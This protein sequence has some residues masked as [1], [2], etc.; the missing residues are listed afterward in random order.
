[1]T[2]VLTVNA[3]SSTIRLN[4]FDCSE[5]PP[6]N[7][8]SHVIHLASEKRTPQQLLQLC[9]R[10]ARKRTPDLIAHRVVHGGPWLS[11]NCRIDAPVEAKI[12]EVAHLA[13]L[14][15]PAALEW[16][17]ACRAQFGADTPQVACFDT[18]EF[19]ELPA[20]AREYPLPAALRQRW[21]L[22]RYGFHGLAHRSM[23]AQFA[24]E[25]AGADKNGRVITL[26]LGSGCS[27]AAFLAGRPIDTSM[28][29][30]PLEGLMMGTRAGDLDPGLLLFLLDRGSLDYSKLASV[31]HERSGLLGVSERSADIR[32]LLEA[33]DEAS[34]LA[35]E[36]FCY[37][38][39]K[40]VGS[41]AAALQGLDAVVFGGGIGENSPDVRRRIME[42]LEFFGIALDA[43]L[44]EARVSHRRRITRPHSKVEVWVVAVDEAALLVR[45]ALDVVAKG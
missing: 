34:R 33:N 36:M 1:M 19:A 5:T 12:A 3:G 18:V 45:E 26:Q 28:G 35:V 15:N 42:P 41:Y 10:D 14:H 39:S 25:N 30:S 7:H 32:D 22:R 44:N 37:R 27:A 4:L 6:L 40:Y 11:A 23:M 9:L 2:E 24:E 16:I 8:V 21:H 38:V 20:I 29:F 13:P 43:T 31:L 17:L